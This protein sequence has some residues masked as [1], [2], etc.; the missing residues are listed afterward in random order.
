MSERPELE[1]QARGH[2]QRLLEAAEKLGMR[3]RPHV[4][5][6]S[7]EDGAVTVEWILS[8]RRVGL[9]IDPNPAESGWWFVSS[10]AWGGPQ[11]MGK[12]DSFDAEMLVRLMMGERQDQPG[13]DDPTEPEPA[14]ARGRAGGARG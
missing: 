8:G 3:D 1:Q 11:K 14:V 9:L 2:V 7:E 12:L 4:G 10:I 6:T 5:M 13:H